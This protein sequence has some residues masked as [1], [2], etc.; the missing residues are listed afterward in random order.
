MNRGHL[1]ENQPTGSGTEMRNF[2][3]LYARPNQKL[4]AAHENQ[5]ADMVAKGQTVYYNATANYTGKNAVPDSLPI[6]WLNLD[7]GEIPRDPI[8]IW[9]TPTGLK[10]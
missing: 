4:M 6:N 8:T 10:P 1:L 3:T 5:V 9:N 7:S 2:V